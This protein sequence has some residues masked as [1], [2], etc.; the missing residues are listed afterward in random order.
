MGKSHGQSPRRR[1]RRAGLE[2][3][4]RTRT[5]DRARQRTAPRNL[6]MKAGR[7]ASSR[8]QRARTIMVPEWHPFR[9][10]FFLFFSSL[11][12]LFFLLF[13][14]FFSFLF[15]RL[16]P[17][18]FLPS[19]RYAL[20]RFFSLRPCSCCSLARVRFARFEHGWRIRVLRACI[21]GCAFRCNASTRFALFHRAPPAGNLRADRGSRRIV[22]LRSRS[23]R[24]KGG[25]RKGCIKSTLR[26]PTKDNERDEETAERIYQKQEEGSGKRE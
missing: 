24:P 5:A 12:L 19:P 3:S 8:M 25:A 20:V 23:G 2:R 18:T 15:I 9:L 4:K 16:A 26:V 11:F 14:L 17:V 22:A 10:L 13:L 21:S 7:R 1:H 6:R